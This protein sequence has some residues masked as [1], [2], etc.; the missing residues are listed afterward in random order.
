M[1]TIATLWPDPSSDRINSLWAIA[2]PLLFAFE[3]IIPRSAIWAA[4]AL[5]NS[6]LFFCCWSSIF[7][8]LSGTDICFSF[9]CPAS[10]LD[11]VD[12]PFG[13]GGMLLLYVDRSVEGQSAAAAPVF[14]LVSMFVTTA[15]ALSCG[16]DAPA[17]SSGAIAQRKVRGLPV[18]F[19]DRTRS[20]VF[21]SNPQAIKASITRLEWVPRQPGHLRIT[22]LT[23]TC[24]L[25]P[26]ATGVP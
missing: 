4:S 14:V 9:P 20:L 12:S 6:V 17:R 25:H 7:F 10:L 3:S 15:R 8:S 5:K 13:A 18:R 1:G 16:I 26:S 11:F 21:L 2:L 23:D 19:V 24:T 22:P